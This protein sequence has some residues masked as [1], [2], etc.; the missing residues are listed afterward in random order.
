MRA[1]TLDD[2]MENLLLR[3]AAL[4]DL[5]DLDEIV[6]SLIR[7]GLTVRLDRLLAAERATMSR[8][9]QT[10]VPED[11]DPASIH[12]ALRQRRQ[13]KQTIIARQQ[14]AAAEVEESKTANM[15]KV[16]N[17]FTAIHDTGVELRVV[18]TPSRWMQVPPA[19]DL[20]REPHRLVLLFGGQHGQIMALNI[21]ATSRGWEVAF[22]DNGQRV[23]GVGADTFSCLQRLV[24]DLIS[25]HEN[26]N[27]LPHRVDRTPARPNR[28]ASAS[29]A[30]TPQ[31]RR[32]RII[33]LLD[34][35]E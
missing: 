29:P 30:A 22:S 34:H 11:A 6:V 19:R 16:L 21:T 23:W 27:P 2:D 35:S 1:F 3:Y 17:L 25:E 33:D 4:A 8:S 10:A 32:E 12:N 18:G 26:P 15:Q 9:A 5:T 24:L 28:R 7:D 20:L 13:V 14:A 31:S